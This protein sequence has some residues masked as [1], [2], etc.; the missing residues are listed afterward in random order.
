MDSTDSSIRKRVFLTGVIAFSVLVLVWRVFLFGDMEPRGDQAFF[1]WWVLGMEASDH[2]LPY[3][4]PGEKLFDAMARDETGFLTQFFRPMYNSPTELLKAISILILYGAAEIFGATHYVQAFVSILASVLLVGVVGLFFYGYRLALDRTKNF[5]HDVLAGVAA[6]VLASF[7][8]HLHS[9]SSLGPHNIGLLF[10]LIAV[11]FSIRLL[12]EMATEKWDGPRWR[13]LLVFGLTQVLALYTY[14]INV[15]LLPPATVLSIIL[16][17]G[18]SLRRKTTYLTYY[19]LFIGVLLAPLIPFFV[20]DASK[21]AFAK[22][23]FTITAILGP[24]F[25][26][27]IGAVLSP[28][29]DRTVEWFRVADELFSIPGTI[30]GLFGLG[31]MAWRSRIIL[32]LGIVV[33]HFAAWCFVPLFAGLSLR[34][35]LYV[36]PFLIIGNAYFLAISAMSLRQCVNGLNRACIFKAGT[37]LLAAGL[38]AVH[39]AS[40][41]PGVISNEK[42]A[43]SVPRIWNE[44]FAGQGKL[45]PMIAQIEQTLP[46]DAVFMTWGYGLQFLFRSL[47]KDTTHVFVP[48]AISAL[49][50]RDKVGTLKTHLV[51]RHLSIA[52]GAPVYLLVDYGIDRTDRKSVVYDV[53]TVLGP[54]GFA[55]SNAVGFNEITSWNLTSSWPREVVLYSLE[56]DPK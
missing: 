34:T 51:R 30:A 20:L 16:C 37:S 27:G 47:K 29:A 53:E 21:P 28:V 5:N 42:M 35:F 1:T 4:D 55:I 48:P 12:Q 19:V 6:L 46:K 40:Q 11:I 33:S 9:F 18:I 45:R 23:P 15:F 2:L 14:K 7:S 38:L 49:M 54:R 24:L 13:P 32:P 22:E 36:V 10:L 3:V 56:L 39:L 50:L 52:S 41:I 17:S 31:L 8:L 26:G 44:Y 43:E 25:S